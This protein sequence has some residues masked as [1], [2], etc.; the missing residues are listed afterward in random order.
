MFNH[1]GIQSSIIID[2]TERKNRLYM[3]TALT[4]Q[5]KMICHKVDKIDGDKKER[6]WKL[7]IQRNDLV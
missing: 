4:W 2:K 5:S 6:T 3:V 1:I 7:E